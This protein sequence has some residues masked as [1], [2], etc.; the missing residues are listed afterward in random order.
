MTTDATQLTRSIAELVLAAPDESARR[1][2]RALLVDYLAV[3]RRGAC[4][5]PARS[6]REALLPAPRVARPARLEGA[7]ATAD[8]LT[9]ALLNG[10]AAHGIELDDTHEP[11]SL[12]PG[13][14]IWPALLALHDQRRGVE[15]PQLL[16][17]GVVGYD[18]ACRTGEWLGAARTYARG[19]HPTS[20]AGV[21]GAAVA[22]ARLLGLDVERTGH[23]VGIAASGAGGLLEF[24]A[25]GSWTK[26]LHAGQAA[27]TGLRAA[28]LAEAG[29]TGPSTAIEGANGMLLAFADVRDVDVLPERAVG[30]GVR[31]TSVKLYP[32]CRYSHGCIDLLLGLVAEY[33]LTPE[34]VTQIECGILSAGW[35]LVAA[36][37]E[38]KRVIGG[39][40]DAQFSMP[41]LAALAVHHGRVALDDVERAAELAGDLQPLV[42]AVVCVRHPQ[43]DARFPREWGAEVVVHTR[44]GARVAASTRAYLG[45]PGNPA[46]ASHLLAKYGSLVGGPLADE[47]V[48]ELDRDLAGSDALE[49]LR[50][51]AAVS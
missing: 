49:R 36:P 13:V 18:A 24:L 32:S 43:L 14:A 31:D 7:D 47:L 20:V 25:D 15:L 1:H 46:Q 37:A 10:V 16:D 21:I 22:A 19:F 50:G 30:D 35:A 44:G 11:A 34:D 38:D 39:A 17:A 2:A 45:S 9:A 5:A 27:S 33:E 40:V 51:S 26:P 12:H 41:F 8:P 23:A 28:L 29:F 4:S 48:A 6:A 42:R 3:A